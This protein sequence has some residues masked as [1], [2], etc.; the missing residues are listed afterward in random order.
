[1][2]VV[3]YFDKRLEQDGTYSYSSTTVQAEPCTDVYPA[4]EYPEL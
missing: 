1:M 2:P 4:E 3:V